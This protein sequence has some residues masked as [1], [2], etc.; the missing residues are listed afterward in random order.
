MFLWDKYKISIDVTGLLLYLPINGIE[1]FRL[2][3]LFLRIEL[4]NNWKR[5]LQ[6]R[7]SIAQ[8]K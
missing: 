4:R 8:W 7:P 1:I 5:I 6:I 2:I 3:E